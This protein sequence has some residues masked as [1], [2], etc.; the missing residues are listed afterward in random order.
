MA[1]SRF[2]FSVSKLSVLLGLLLVASCSKEKTG[3]EIPSITYL[4]YEKYQ[5]GLGKDSLLVIRFNFE[6]G[7]GDIGYN[8]S[9]TLAPFQ[10]GD[11]FFYNLHTD[12]FGLNNGM[13]VYYIDGF[14][15]D[16]ISYNQR[17]PSITP[18]GKY[19]EITGTM[20]LR[21]DFAIVLLNG[22]DPKRVQLELWLNDRAL[23]ES[24]R[25]LTPEINLDI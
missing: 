14:S 11:P 21:V 17:L 10:I 4:G 12:F 6:D 9:D 25:I 19:K 8:E 24:N 16:T 7:N 3:S 2:I 15:N 5:N 23:N 22:H 13:K 20:E 18:E 1:A